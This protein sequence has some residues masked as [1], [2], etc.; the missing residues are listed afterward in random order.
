MIC[1][2]E[3][4]LREV[5]LPDGACFSVP[6]DVVASVEPEATSSAVRS[7]AQRAGLLAY[8]DEVGVF[9]AA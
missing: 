8:G 4:T 5:M 3:P 7:W 6:A 9:Q 2:Y 1:V